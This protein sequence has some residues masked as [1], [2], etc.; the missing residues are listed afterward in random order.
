MSVFDWKP[1]YGVPRGI[2]GAI[3]YQ[4]SLLFFFFGQGVLVEV[5]F[6]EVFCFS[7]CGKCI[8]PFF[9]LFGTYIFVKFVL[10]IIYVVCYVMQCP[11]RYFNT[12]VAKFIIIFLLYK[13]CKVFNRH[14]STSVISSQTTFTLSAFTFALIIFN[15]CPMSSIASLSGLLFGK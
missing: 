10:K 2:C 9:K 8:T 4:A 7:L 3:L 12:S 11:R 13:F 5:V 6:D 14:F 15:F 1:L